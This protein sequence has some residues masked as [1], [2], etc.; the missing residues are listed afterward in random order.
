[1]A[2]NDYFEQ[3]W[4]QL[5]SLRSD[6]PTAVGGEGLRRAT[7]TSSLEQAEQMFRA[8]AQVGTATRPLPLFYGLSQ[9]GR[10]IACAAKAAKGDTWRLGGHGITSGHLD[11]PLS[12]V[13]VTTQKKGKPGSFVRVSE[14]LDSPVWEETEQPLTALWDALPENSGWPLSKE[15]AVRQLPLLAQTLVRESDGPHP[16][17]SLSVMF[18]PSVVDAGSRE[19][20]MDYLRDY[21]EAQGWDSFVRVGSS[22]DAGPEFHVQNGWG[23]YPP[24]WGYATLHWTVEAPWTTSAQDRIAFLQTLRRSYSNDEHL[25]F[26]PSLGTG[27]SVHPLMAWWAVLHA[28]SMLARYQPAEWAQHIS[29]DRSTYAAAIERLLA[30]GIE[31]VPGLL[32]QVLLD[33]S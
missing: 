9:A 11:G 18:P 8:A 15:G 1:M 19:A 24:G 2:T 22:P 26:F 33:V 29:I 27:R 4:Y 31:T 6:P 20:M 25:L 32:L 3:T 16:L 10:A 21:P 17:A 13:T 7:F 23:W 30:E 14:L 28:F 12:A 5:R